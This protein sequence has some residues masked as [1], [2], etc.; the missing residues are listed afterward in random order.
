MG[1][2][3]GEIESRT[4]IKQKRICP[5]RTGE[6]IARQF[7]LGLNQKSIC[8]T[9]QR[10]WEKEWDFLYSSKGSSMMYWILYIG[11]KSTVATPCIFWKVSNRRDSLH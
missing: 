1:H 2:K 9:N 5:K 3:F 11:K 8:I 4:H 10:T 6:K 7:N